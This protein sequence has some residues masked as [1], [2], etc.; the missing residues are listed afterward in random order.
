MLTSLAH[1][2]LSPII[3]LNKEK[4]KQLL[5]NKKKLTIFLKNMMND[6]KGLYDIELFVA[7]KNQYNIKTFLLICLFLN[8]NN[9]RT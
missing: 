6:I 3:S 1:L 9:S 5:L 7:I 8:K 4:K 2:F